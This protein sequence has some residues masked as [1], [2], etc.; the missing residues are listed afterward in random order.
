MKI[1]GLTGGVGS[2]KSSVSHFFEELGMPI[3]DADVIAHQLVTK[4]MP[5]LEQIKEVF[6]TAVI[7]SQGNLNRAKMRALIFTHPGIEN[8][9]RAKLESILHPLI[10]KE[11]KNQI[12]KL[13][14]TSPTT[15]Y[16]VAVIPLL[17]ENYDISREMIDEIIVIDVP[18]NVQ[19]GRLLQREKEKSLTLEQALAIIHNQVSRDVRLSMADTILLNTGDLDKL[20]KTV[21]KLHNTLLKSSG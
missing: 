18:E 11:I 10:F 16:C 21:E 4:G 5:P 2:G 3:I 14:K 9:Y 17:V 7:D 6:G 12:D 1:I 15:P 20:K 19:L 8:P 13:K